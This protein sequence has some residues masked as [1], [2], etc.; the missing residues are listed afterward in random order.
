MFRK[1]K[2]TKKKT[3]FRV[4]AVAII[5]VK[6]DEGLSYDGSYR[7]L[8]LFKYRSRRKT[9]KEGRILPN[10]VVE[11]TGYIITANLIEHLLYT[12][13]SACILVFFHF[14]IFIRRLQWARHNF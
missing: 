13:L 7:V 6:N 11:R 8:W 5:Q 1:R 3:G 2:R 9:R 4:E 12:V 10:F 14:T